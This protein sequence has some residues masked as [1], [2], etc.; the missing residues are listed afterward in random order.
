MSLTLGQTLPALPHQVKDCALSKKQPILNKQFRILKE[1]GE[2]GQG[3]VYE[4]FTTRGHRTVAIKVAPKLKNCY[5]RERRDDKGHVYV[6][7]VCPD[8]FELEIKAYR[9]LGQFDLPTIPIIYGYTMCRKKTFLVSEYIEHATTFNETDTELLLNAMDYVV[10][11]LLY[12]IK[13]MQSVKISHSDIHG[14]NVLIQK[15][16][17]LDQFSSLIG[18]GKQEVDISE[19]QGFGS[20]APYLIDFGLIIHEHKDHT[21]LRPT[22][23][24]R[25]PRYDPSRDTRMLAEMIH[26][27][28]PNDVSVGD[29]RAGGSIYTIQF[30]EL[31][32]DDV[33]KD[34]D[35]IH[36]IAVPKSPESYP[37]A[38]HI[39]TQMFLQ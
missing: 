11:M 27:W 28:Y 33:L 35:H 18:V 10:V 9:L 8:S 14:S 34:S 22:E 31:I 4:A 3:K 25:S 2:G 5:K 29:M 26:K 20:V 30:F 21:L 13:F 17:A 7:D 16:L 19:I 36:R 23:S 39:L 32:L 1:I 6:D 37:S 38:E 12:T 15:R 24:W